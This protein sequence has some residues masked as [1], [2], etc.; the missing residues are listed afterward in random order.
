MFCSSCFQ[1]DVEGLLVGDVPSHR[2]QHD[3]Q[4]IVDECECVSPNVDSA[5]LRLN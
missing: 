5:L 1:P 2:K 4:Q 3:T